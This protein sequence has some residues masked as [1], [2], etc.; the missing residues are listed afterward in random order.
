[1]MVSVVRFRH[2][3]V[4][5]NNREDLKRKKTGLQPNETTNRTLAAALAAFSSSA[6]CLLSIFLYSL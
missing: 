4:K 2:R 5:Q 3:E 1:M 6:F